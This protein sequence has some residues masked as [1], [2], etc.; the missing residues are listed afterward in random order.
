MTVI[1]LSLTDPSPRFATAGP[2]LFQIRGNSRLVKIL[3]TPTV[4]TADR[5]E[6][7]QNPLAT[8]FKEQAARQLTE[9]E[10]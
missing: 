3:F 9:E 10:P 4:R 5:M 1:G 7:C 8:A 2:A 6:K